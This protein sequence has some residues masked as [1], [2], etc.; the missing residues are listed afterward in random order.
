MST[1]I[2]P[3]EFDLLP[4]EVPVTLGK[5]KYILREAMGDAAVQYTNACIGSQRMDEEGNKRIVGIAD[6]EPLLVSLCLFRLDTQGNVEK[7][8]AGRDKHVELSLVRSW[9]AKVQRKLYETA[10]EISCLVDPGDTVESLEKFISQAQ[11]K[12][13]V[14]KNG[15]EQLKNSQSSTTDGSS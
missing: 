15:D 6:A 5:D 1:P 9:P 4:Q 10:K 8:R 13:A 12:L 3:I 2:Q 7:D 11:K 14:L